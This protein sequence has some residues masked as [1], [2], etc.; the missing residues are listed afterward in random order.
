MS[1]R[2]GTIRLPARDIAVP[3][4]V[5]GEAQAVLANPPA[6]EKTCRRST[7]PRRGG[8]DRRPRRRHRGDDG[9]AGRS[10]PVTVVNRD[11][12]AARL[13]DHPGR[14]RRR[15]RAGLPRHPRRRVHLGRRRALRRDGGRHRGPSGRPG[16]GGRLPEP[17]D[18]PFP[19]ALDRLA[20]YRA[21]LGE[22]PPERV[23]IGGASAGGNL[24]AALIL[25]ARDEGLPLPG[26]GADDAGRGPQ[27]GRRLPS[28]QPGARSP[29]P[30]QLE[31]GVPALRGR[32]GPQPPVPLAAE[33]RLHQGLP[34]AILTTGTRDMLL[35]D[36]VLLHGALRRAGVPAELHVTEAGGHGGFMGMAPE[37]RRSCARS[38]AS[39]TPIGARQRTGH[40]TQVGPNPI[41]VSLG[42]AAYRPVGVR[43]WVIRVTGPTPPPPIAVVRPALPPAADRLFLSLWVICGEYRQF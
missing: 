35:S 36:T 7:T 28:D 1:E 24:A 9:G 2:R 41:R 38:G 14:S 30:W 29:H 26:R 22:R 33:R 40:S 3:S 6:E 23:I 5:S 13:R 32:P 25:R 21:L 31:A 12:A 34:A 8:D 17:P 37:T 19:A 43:S 10:A 15:R 18:H 39:P 42:F 4:T 20:A 16:V 27:Q 11:L